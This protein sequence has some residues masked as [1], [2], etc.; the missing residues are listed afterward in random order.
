MRS[1]VLACALFGMAMG[2][3]KSD[4]SKTKEMTGTWAWK[5]RSELPPDLVVD[6]G[7]PT[8]EAESLELRADGTYVH[9]EQIPGYDTVVGEKPF[10]VSERWEE[11]RGTWSFA[12][13]E[14]SLGESTPGD[15]WG[16]EP[17]GEGLA[18]RADRDRRR[19]HVRARRAHQ[20]EPRAPRSRR[21]RLRPQAP[22]RD[23]DARTPHDRH[24]EALRAT[25]LRD[26]LRIRGEATLPRTHERCARA[27]EP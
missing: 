4:A 21:R 10:H 16:R 26:F 7:F 8:P 14:L 25:I 19:A 24:D 23:R 11:W 18:N 2:A 9:V 13:G 1:F 17:T 5:P 12:K 27:P 22:R 3:C 6:K 15:R 20:D